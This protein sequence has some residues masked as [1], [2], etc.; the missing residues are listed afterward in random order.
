MPAGSVAFNST[1]VRHIW[2]AK[3]DRGNYYPSTELTQAII[4]SA[5]YIVD[6]ETRM[7]DHAFLERI[8]GVKVIKP[9]AVLLFGRSND[10]NEG[11]QQSYRVLNC[12]FHDLTILTYDHVLARAKRM[13]GIGGVDK[14]IPM[15]MSP[16][17]VDFLTC[18][19]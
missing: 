19:F 8:G 3:Q 9:R 13:L 16:Q 4:Q 17:E 2:A 11:H 1:I 14:Q 18:P 7:N 15:A 5:Q 6:V 12:S 10:W